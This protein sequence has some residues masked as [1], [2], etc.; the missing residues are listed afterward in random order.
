VHRK[1]PFSNPFLCK[2]K[3]TKEFSTLEFMNGAV[4]LM[5]YFLSIVRLRIF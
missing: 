3:K 4:F 1:V 5:K 2:K